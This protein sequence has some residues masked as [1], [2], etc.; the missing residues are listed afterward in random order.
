MQPSYGAKRQFSASVDLIASAM[1]RSVMHQHAVP[2]ATLTGERNRMV[3]IVVAV[4]ASIQKQC[5]CWHLTE[6]LQLSQ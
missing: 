6:N 2:G 5:G 1:R 3:G 4:P